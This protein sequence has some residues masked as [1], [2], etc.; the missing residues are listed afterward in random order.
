MAYMS[1][2]GKFD[3]QTFARQEFQNPR[4]AKKNV[5]KMCDTLKA[6]DD[7]RAFE[8]NL[9]NLKVDD[10]INS[11]EDEPEYVEEVVIEN[12]DD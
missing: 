3:S 12:T 2:F 6:L 7:Q 4:I 11:H 10:E 9:E 8:F 5:E 1:K